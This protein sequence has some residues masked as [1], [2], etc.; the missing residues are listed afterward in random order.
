M[1][2]GFFC[3]S[4]GEQDNQ[5]CNKQKKLLKQLKFAECLEKKG[6]TSKVNLEVIKPW[7]T[8]RNPDSKMMQINLTGF[9]NGKNA[10]EFVGEL[11]PLLLSAQGNIM[12]IPSA[13]LELKKEEIKQRQIEQEKLA[14]MKKQ[15][16]DKD[17][18][19]RE[20]KESSREKRERSG[21][22][23][24][25][26][27]PL[28]EETK[29]SHYR[30]P[31][32][33]TKSQSPFAPEK[34]EKTPELPEPSVKVKEPSIE[35]ATSTGDILKVPKPEPNL[36]RKKK[37]KSKKETSYSPRRRPSPRRQPSPRRRTP[38]RRMP[39]PPRHRRSRS[40]LIILFIS[41][42]VTTKEASQEDIQPPR[43]TCRLS[44]SA[45][46]PRRRHRPSPPAT[47]PPKT[48][49]SPTPQQSNRTR[50]SRVSVSPGRTS[51][52]EKR[53]SASP[54][55]KPRKV[56]LSESEEDKGGKMAAA[57][58][59]QQRCPYRRQNQQSSSDSGSSSSKEDE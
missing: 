18:R 40:P 8:K 7:I 29:R 13:F 28:L 10:R 47:P 46:P 38:P 15:D 17:K 54:A 24:R 33:R 19:H 57:D 55:P 49:H 53:E 11:W 41:F 31:G 44:P 32:H 3:R 25:Y 21:S 50:K 9:S 52:T 36:L 1:H 20:E 30:S 23:G 14:S 39:P 6:D 34:K 56:G 4:S 43:K 5:F 58:S 59:V 37:K 42:P 51:G 16:K 48:R 26:N 35:Q 12:G 27:L 45:S 22:P 2:V